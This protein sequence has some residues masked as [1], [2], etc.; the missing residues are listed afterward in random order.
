MENNELLERI[1][2]KNKWMRALYMILYVVVL[3][4]VKIIMYAVVLLQFFLVL[5]TN[6]CNENLLHFSKHISTY[7][8][9]IYLFLSYNSEE[10]PFPFG[11]WPKD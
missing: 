7:V 10:K 11:P 2:E 5:I 9:Q 6:H 4:I 1:Q 8:Y 3:W